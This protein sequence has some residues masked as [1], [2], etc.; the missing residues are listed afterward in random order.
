VKGYQSDRVVQTF[1]AVGSRRDLLWAVAIGLPALI[2]VSVGAGA[3][4]GAQ[5]AQGD[6]DEPGAGP[7][8]ESADGS[9]PA[10]SRQGS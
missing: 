7:A 4:Q 9:V 1:D 6:G 3:K 5:A 10:T 2:L 8:G